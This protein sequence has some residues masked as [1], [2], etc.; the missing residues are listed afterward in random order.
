MG[1]DG[2]AAPSTQRR[3]LQRRW[4]LLCPQTAAAAAD[5]GLPPGR[6][7]PRPPAPLLATL[8][9]ASPREPAAPRRSRRRRRMRLRRARWRG[10]GFSPPAQRRWLPRGGAA[11]PPASLRC[12]QPGRT[13]GPARCAGRGG[14]AEG[15]L[16]AE[17][18]GRCGMG[19][20]DRWREERAALAG[21]GSV[22]GSG[23]P[24]LPLTARQK[25]PG[26]VPRGGAAPSPRPPWSGGCSRPVFHPPPAKHLSG[27]RRHLR[28]PGAWRPLSCKRGT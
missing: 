28:A 20:P 7:L 23:P 16:P 24:R 6:L 21:G 3:R 8:A 9:S 12:D 17:K 4:A 1:A 25:V 13:C 26:E 2:G 27:P 11:L 14:A 10:G 22:P 15:A 5:T 19:L 18:G